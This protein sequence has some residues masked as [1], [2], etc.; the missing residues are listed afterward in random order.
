MYERNLKCIFDFKRGRGD[1][2]PMMIYRVKLAGRLNIFSKIKDIGDTVNK[3]SN[4]KNRSQHQGTGP[5]QL[6][7]YKVLYAKLA[8]WISF[9]V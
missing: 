3:A 1:A 8:C 7:C 2:S 9:T 4:N 6:S 5:H